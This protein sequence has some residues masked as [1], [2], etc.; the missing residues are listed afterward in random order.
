MCDG[1][2]PRFPRRATPRHVWRE[3]PCQ[4]RVGGLRDP[5]PFSQ[6]VTTQN[7]YLG[8]RLTVLLARIAFYA[9]VIPQL[10]YS[11]PGSAMTPGAIGPPAAKRIAGKPTGATLPPF[12]GLCLTRLP[13]TPSR[14][15]RCF[16]RP[17]CCCC[18][19]CPAR[20]PFGQRAA[21]STRSTHRGLLGGALAASTERPV[22]CSI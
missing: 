7:I 22:W 11:T 3:G 17:G 18:R 15:P 4:V 9:P 6:R 21:P 16:Y 2:F 8:G 14:K 5:D 19:A 10:D 1:R 12:Y 20:V 13:T